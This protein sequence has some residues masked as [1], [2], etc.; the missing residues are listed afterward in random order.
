MIIAVV[1]IVPWFWFW[2][3]FLVSLGLGFSFFILAMF[4][5]LLSILKYP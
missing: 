1:Q 3:C 2:S 5:A 4:V